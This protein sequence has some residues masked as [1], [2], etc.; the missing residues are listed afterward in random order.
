MRQFHALLFLILCGLLAAGIGLR[1][2]LT[3]PSPELFIAQLKSHHIQPP[4]QEGEINSTHF[5]L[6]DGPSQQRVPLTSDLF[7]LPVLPVYHN[8]F[9][10][11]SSQNSEAA[12]AYLG[13][14]HPTHSFP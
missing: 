5:Q 10:F 3:Q 8:Y 13:H 11:G 2:P 12:R 14:L 4:Q 1:V 7:F 6:H 9:A